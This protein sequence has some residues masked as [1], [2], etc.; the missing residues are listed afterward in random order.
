MQSSNKPIR[1]W[2]KILIDTSIIC[3]LFRFQHPNINNTSDA[4]VSKLIDYLSQSKASDRS[5][6]VFLIT[7]ITLTELLTKEQ[8]QDKIKLISRVLNSN[9]VRFISFDTTTSLAFNHLLKPYLDKTN[10]H[11]KAAEI[12][13]KTGEYMMARE[14][15]TRDYMIALNGVIKEADAILTLDKN[16]FYPV[17]KDVPDANCILTYP[18]LFRFSE[19]HFFDYDYAN[20]DNY[21]KRISFKTLNQFDAEN[22]KNATQGELFAEDLS[23]SNTKALDVEED[24]L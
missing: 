3:S 15:I 8:D 12:G 1:D 4:F 10:L 21:I 16:T 7:T 23:D 13:F 9:N 22:P 20:V 2:K 5:E 6:R 18:E 24:P 14:W 17:I 11:A 19:S